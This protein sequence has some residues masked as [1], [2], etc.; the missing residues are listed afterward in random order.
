MVEP[1]KSSTMR[2]MANPAILLPNMDTTLPAVIIVKSL[3]HKGFVAVFFSIVS[4]KTLFLVSS[5]LYSDIKFK[6]N[7]NP[8]SFRQQKT[9]RVFLREEFSK[10]PSYNRASYHQ[11]PEKCHREIHGSS[12][13]PGGYCICCKSAFEKD[14]SHKAHDGAHE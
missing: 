7:L 1:V 9:P 5:Q 14:G 10:K 13:N 11:L 2:L 3:V 4:P 8:P 12:L 6:D